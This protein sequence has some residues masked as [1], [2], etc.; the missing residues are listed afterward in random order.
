MWKNELYVL[1]DKNTLIFPEDDTDKQN[2]TYV[3]FMFPDVYGIPYSRCPENE[4]LTGYANQ[5]NHLV[6]AMDEK[7]I[8]FLDI[9]PLY[10]WVETTETGEI[11]HPS[12]ILS[13]EVDKL[14]KYV[15]SGDIEVSEIS[16]EYMLFADKNETYDIKPVWVVYYYQNQL[17]TGENSYTQKMAL[18]DV[19]DAYTGEEYRIQW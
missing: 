9:P 3:F 13:K 16:L 2:D 12:S 1:D 4:A 15:T 14:K 18:Y 6:I 7:G 19:Y 8:S 10:D 5:E 17:V 11:L